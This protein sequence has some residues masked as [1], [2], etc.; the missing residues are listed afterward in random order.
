MTLH[1]FDFL[2]NPWFVFLWYGFG[3][4]AAAGILYDTLNINRNVSAPLKAAWPIIVIFFSIIGLALYLWSC[5]PTHI[6]KLQ[7]QKPVEAARAHHAFVSDH[8]KK[9]IG[10]TAHC[11]GGDGLG[12]M[13]AMIVTRLWGFSFWREFLIEYAAGFL[14]GWLIFQTWAMR[15]MNNSWPMAVWKGGRAEFF[16]MLTLMLGMG[17]IMRFITP[18]V[19]GG[20]PRPDTAAFWG[21]AG[22]GLMVGFV[23]TYPMN[24][25]LVRIGWKHGMA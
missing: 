18:A 9:V 8:W 11:V 15:Q 10:S 6:G 7:A 5:R 21:L 23:F 3:V 1:F 19:A 24:S 13:S 14:F 22:F 4:A 16:S 20:A 17:L 12:I 2:D 25:W